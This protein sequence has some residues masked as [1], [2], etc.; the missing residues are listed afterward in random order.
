MYVPCRPHAPLPPRPPRPLCC[1]VTFSF[2]SECSL[3]RESGLLRDRSESYLLSTPS[4]FRNTSTGVD[5]GR[6]PRLCKLRQDQLSNPTPET[7]VNNTD[8]FTRTRFGGGVS[9]IP[10]GTLSPAGP[11]RHVSSSGK[12][13]TRRACP[14]TPVTEFRRGVGSRLVVATGTDGEG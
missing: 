9:R 5:R 11:C 3:S 1:T 8:S 12:G 4:L 13:S 7:E 14:D 10:W 6:D 2:W